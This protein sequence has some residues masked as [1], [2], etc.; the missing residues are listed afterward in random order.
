MIKNVS[1]TKQ[2]P[3]CKELAIFENEHFCSQL[4]TKI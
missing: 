3:I 2:K 4:K 1:E